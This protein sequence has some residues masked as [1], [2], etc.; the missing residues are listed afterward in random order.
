MI[1]SYYKVLNVPE[2]LKNK[3]CLI[4]D[5][6]YLK[7]Y[8]PNTLINIRSIT[9]YKFSDFCNKDLEFIYDVIYDYD[10]KTRTRNTIYF[11]PDY[12]IEVKFEKHSGD[13]NWETRKLNTND[14]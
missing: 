9:E 6:L 5:V 1:N 3:N 8:L 13:Y 7:P 4:N 10:G 12:S 11:Y 2:N 14:L